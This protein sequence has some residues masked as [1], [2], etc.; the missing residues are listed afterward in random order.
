M[1]DLSSLIDLP[2]T[3]T[4]RDRTQKRRLVSVLQLVHSDESGGVEALAR[5]ISAGLE[6][7]GAH[8]ET[9]FIYPNISAPLGQ[10]LNGIASTIAAIARNRPD[11][12]IAYQS[13][14]SVIA[15]VAGALT[16]C[17]RRIVHQ[18]AMPSEVHPAVRLL[19][20]AI[21][22][23]G[24][25]SVNIANSA[26]TEHAFS[27]YPRRYHKYMRRIDHGLD[28]PQ[29]HH[30]R[31]EVL[32]RYAIPDDGLLLFNAGRLCEQKG[33]DRAIRALLDVGDARLI[34]AGGGPGETRLTELARSLGVQD[35]VHFLG[36]L[37]RNEID[38][39]LGAVDMLVF[40]SLWE[41]FGLAAVEAAMAGVAIVAAD[42]P[43]L[44]EVLSAG[45]DSPVHFVDAANPLAL[46][47]AIETQ[48][49]K[50]RDNADIRKFAEAIS[51]KYS[52]DRMLASYD[53]L[54]F[55]TKD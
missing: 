36:A 3:P 53:E 47:A 4:T 31:S 44:R 8:V 20:T 2:E 41:T 14:A 29:A 48:R 55:G 6:K 40:P 43:V 39:L 30:S 45:G 24:F 38:D 32:S 27:D 22:S 23:L 10:K 17:K 35:R 21:G 19:D 18:T 15:G 5:M 33:Q 26:A 49:N 11:A 50:T 7:R 37:S 25:Y 28:A 42:L 34:L 16:G 51:A 46:A 52:Q 13:T 1:T 54:I 9:R 12:L